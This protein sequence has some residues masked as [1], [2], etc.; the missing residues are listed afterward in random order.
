MSDDLTLTPTPIDVYL[1]DQD[2]R[3][4][5]KRAYYDATKPQPRQSTGLFALVVGVLLGRFLR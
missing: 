3:L 1:K 2:E 5:A 4:A